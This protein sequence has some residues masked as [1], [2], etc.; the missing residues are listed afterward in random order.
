M[1][2]HHFW[3]FMQLW[4]RFN[5]ITVSLLS[6]HFITFILQLFIN[7]TLWR[8]L[9][10]IFSVRLMNINNNHYFQMNRNLNYYLKYENLEK[11]VYNCSYIMTTNMFNKKCLCLLKTCHVAS[12]Q[13]TPRTLPQFCVTPKMYIERY[14]YWKVCVCSCCIQKSFCLLSLLTKFLQ[15]KEAQGYP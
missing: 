7:V 14:V 2:I 12:I 9:P 6:F 8:S 11:N 15:S 3:K 10:L 4:R 1:L 5:W 13:A